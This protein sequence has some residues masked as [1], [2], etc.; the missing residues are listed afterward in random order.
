M[1]ISLYDATVPSWLQIIGSIRAL[2]EKAEAYCAEKGCTAD[3]IIAARITDDMLPFNWQVRW[4]A[5]HSIG[6]IEG[7]RAG[8]FAPDRSDPPADYAGL[9]ALIGTAIDSLSAITVEEMESF[10]GRDM[11][12]V[13]P[14]M[15]LDI[16][17]TAE[18]FLLSFSQP[19]FYFH[20]TTAYD[21]MRGKGVVI[22]KRDF[23]GAMRIKAPA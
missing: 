5:T 11:R 10:I 8:V 6:A 3:E 4:V 17:F 2:L 20:A 9:K 18:N 7:V 23:L 12:F 19:N 1:P 13:I 14:S 22:G 16:P 15:D 21:I